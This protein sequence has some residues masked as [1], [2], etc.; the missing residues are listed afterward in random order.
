MFNFPCFNYSQPPSIKRRTLQ[1]KNWKEKSRK[2]MWRV[3]LISCPWPL[4]AEI[5]GRKVGRSLDHSASH[6]ALAREPV[7]LL[8]RIFSW[9]SAPAERVSLDCPV[10]T[11]PIFSPMGPLRVRCGKLRGDRMGLVQ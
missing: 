10:P 3:T 2:G 4:S 6:L 5:V 7:S 8:G 1:F 11:R 9:R